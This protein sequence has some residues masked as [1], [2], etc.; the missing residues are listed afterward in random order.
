MNR[1][2]TRTHLDQQNCLGSI[3]FGLLDLHAVFS[4]PFEL[5]VA[6]YTPQDIPSLLDPLAI[7]STAISDPGFRIQDDKPVDG[8]PRARYT[9]QWGT[10][11]M[12]APVANPMGCCAALLCPCP[13]SM[14]LRYLVLE[15]DVSKYV[16]C[17]G[18]YDI[19]CHKAGRYGE[20]SCPWVCM[21]VESLFCF[22][23]SISSTRMTIMDTRNIMPDPCDNRLIRFSNMLQWLSCICNMLAMVMDEFDA[24][25]SIIDFAAD[26]VFTIISTCMQAQVHHEVTNHPRPANFGMMG[27][28]T[29]IG[30]GGKEGTLPEQA[31]M[32][33]GG[34]GGGFCPSC[35]ARG[36][37][38]RFCGSCGAPM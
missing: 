25:A 13:M 8:D 34:G 16:C 37:G 26:V 29:R 22:S 19:A 21:A 27:T 18:Y 4:N 20:S 36:N 17:Q 35:G 7:H 9:N 31:R 5:T 24:L 15:K 33:A 23:C 10:G 38:G 6:F 3:F 28:V 32:G 12:N 30:A 14:Y 2:E 11:M 1:N